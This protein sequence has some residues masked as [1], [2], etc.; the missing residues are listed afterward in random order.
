MLSFITVSDF[1]NSQD[2]ISI[3]VTITISENHE[4]SVPKIGYGKPEKFNG[5]HPRNL[6]F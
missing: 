4:Q 5:L 2:N 3:I 1:H 6:P